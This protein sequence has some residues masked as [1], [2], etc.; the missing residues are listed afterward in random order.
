M[1]APAER[2]LV[3]E[4][5]AGDNRAL[6]RLAADGILPLEREELVTLQVKLAEGADAEIAA[7]AHGS[8]S[9]LDTEFL[10][11]YLRQEAGPDVLAYFARVNRDPVVVEAVLQRREVPVR[12]LVEL[13]PVVGSDLQEILLLRQDLIVENP[14][15]LD[16]LETNPKLSR[17]ARRRIAEYRQHLLGRP[18]PIAQPAPPIEGLDDLSDDERWEI[19][20]A[21]EDVREEVP[22]EGEVDTLTGLSEGQ[23]R[24]LPAPVRTKLARGASRT[25]RSILIRDPNPQVATSVLRGS[26]IS[27]PEIELAAANRQVCEEV[28]TTIAG[29]REWAS[30]YTI[31]QQ[32]VRNPRTPVGIAVK[33]VSRMSVRDLGLLRN[34]RNVAD[35]V[36]QTAARLHRLKL[37]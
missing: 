30:K 28:L 8:L 2:S 3:E 9:R 18:G 17:F 34:D 4:V 31:Q 22:G 15:L 13:A 35:A 11:P 19:L 24:A 25:L 12:V 29:R 26:G 21:V 37:Q 32:L 20:D 16:T 36:R 33:F 23:I 5:L 6:Q 27:E 1:T 10:L 7:R 14:E